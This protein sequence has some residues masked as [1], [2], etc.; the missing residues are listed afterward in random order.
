MINRISRRDWLK[1]GAAVASGL[2]ISNLANAQTISLQNLNPTPENPI[3]LG[4]NENVYGPSFKAQAAM[5]KA[6]ARAHLYGM[7]AIAPLKEIIS[8]MEGIPTDYISVACGSSPFLEKAAFMAKIE[9]GAI[10]APYPTYGTI[11]E[12]AA[13]IGAEVI[14]VPVDENMH[15]DLD[16][17]RAAMTDK[18]RLIYLCN[19][20]NP[21]PTIMEK[22]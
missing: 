21:L 18:V 20:N 15:I 12:T 11:I 4:S 16:A 2:A 3:R 5:D 14:N 17:M 9:D 6:K 13:S 1:G 22:N 10:L 19:P 7:P 8:T